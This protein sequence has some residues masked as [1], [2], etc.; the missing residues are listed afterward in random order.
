MMESIKHIIETAV[1]VGLYT[2]LLA[3]ASSIHKALHQTRQEKV[4]IIK[5]NTDPIRYWSADFTDRIK[6]SNDL[7]HWHPNIKMAQVWHRKDIAKAYMTKHNIM[8]NAIEHYIDK[9]TS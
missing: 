1:G 6:D 8:G 2:L 3:L 9:Q 5:I 4:Y 7:R